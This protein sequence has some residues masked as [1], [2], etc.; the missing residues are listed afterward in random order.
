MKKVLLSAVFISLFVSAGAFAADGKAIAGKNACLGCH[1]VDK[2]LVGPA[3]QDVAAKYKG[4]PDAVAKLMKKVKAG[5]SGVWGPVPMPANPGLSDADLKTV[6][7]W[8]LAGAK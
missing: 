7:E 6:V 2:K 3:Y 8:V 5:G 1:A 4:Q